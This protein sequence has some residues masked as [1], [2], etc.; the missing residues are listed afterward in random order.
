MANEVRNFDVWT[1][2]LRHVEGSHV[3]SGYRPVLI[4]STD[5]VN[6]YSPV[7]T[8]LPLTSKEKAMHLF[9][10]VR[11]RMDGHE[12]SSTALVEQITT[13][14]KDRLV[15]KAGRVTDPEAREKVR[16]AISRFLNFAA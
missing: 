10:H 5:E 16:Y 1:V 15:R 3:Q 11:I 2:N 13:I 14:D 4:V 7:V 6:R 12:E 8:V 9:S